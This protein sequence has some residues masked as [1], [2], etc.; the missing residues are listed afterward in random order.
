MVIGY[1]LSV[2]SA[3]GYPYFL[4]SQGFLSVDDVKTASNYG[5]R[6]VV[7]LKTTTKLQKSGDNWKIIKQ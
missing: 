1:A 3:V 2:G 4:N 6:P 7:R 5:L